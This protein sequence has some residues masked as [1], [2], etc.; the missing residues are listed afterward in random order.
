MNEMVELLVVLGPR[1][2]PGRAG[3]Q[4]IGLEAL[5]VVLGGCLDGGIDGGF[6]IGDLLDGLQRDFLL[7]RPRS[8]RGEEIADRLVGVGGDGDAPALA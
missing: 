6:A 1:E 2:Q 8:D 5:I 4:R 3:N 7:A